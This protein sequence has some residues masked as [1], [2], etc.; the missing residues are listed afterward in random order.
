MRP[1][2]Y[3][4][5][6]SH[7]Y[8]CFIFQVGGPGDPL[9]TPSIYPIYMG[10]LY[11]KLEAQVT[12]DVSGTGTESRVPGT[13]AGPG[14]RVLGGR[15]RVHINRSQNLEKCAFLCSFSK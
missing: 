10:V 4:Y 8:G 15:D 7:I 12:R 3:P 9:T 6:I 11:A 13:R 5:Y 1:T 14:S 2:N